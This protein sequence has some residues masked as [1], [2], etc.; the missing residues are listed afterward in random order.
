MLCCVEA[1]AVVMPQD[2]GNYPPIIA[3]DGPAAA[4]KSTVARAVAA[5]LGLTYV[6]TGAM[7]RALTLKALREGVDPEDGAALGRLAARTEISFRP[8]AVPGEPQ[9][10]LLDGRDV[11]GDIR[12]KEV[13]LAVS[14][15]SRHV[16]VRRW[17]RSRQREMA[18]GGGVVMEGRDIGTVV[19]PRADLKVF[20]DGS[21]ECRAARRFRELTAGGCGPTEDEVRRNMARRDAIDSTREVAPLTAAPDAVVIDTTNMTAQDVADEV[22]RLIRG[23]GGGA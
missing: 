5:R 11:S 21:L 3:I 19:L 14:P 17:F 15:V 1:K 22:V 12:T 16:E 8:A 4:G 18:R 9:T 20:L 2:S 13:D 10:V 6:D 7:F 23:L